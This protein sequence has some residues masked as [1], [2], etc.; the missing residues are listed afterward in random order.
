[1]NKYYVLL[2]GILTIAAQNIFC[3]TEALGSDLQHSL[4]NN[5]GEPGFLSV[6]FSLLVV[7]LLIY[8]TGIIYSKLNVIGTKKVRDQLAN[9]DLHKAIVISTTQLGQ[10]KNLHVIELNK[11]HYLIGA[12]PN[13]INLIK[14]LNLPTEQKQEDAENT[15]D[16]DIDDAI[17]V[18]YSGKR[19]EM[20]VKEEA[21]E[22][23]EEFDVHKKYL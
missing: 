23:V 13:S 21:S 12:T 14:E 5:S 3:A 11:K 2:V 19:G 1:M 8:V 15:V 9:Y 20:A 22:E 6:I 7:V 4:K 17:R 16:S 10:N 18:L